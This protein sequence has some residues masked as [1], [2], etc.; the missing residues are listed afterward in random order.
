MSIR[1]NSIQNVRLS[2]IIS[3]W[4]LINIKEVICFSSLT[5]PSSYMLKQQQQQ[6]QKMDDIIINNKRNQIKHS[7]FESKNIL[8]MSKNYNDDSSSSP[9]NAAI[10]LVSKTL[11]TSLENLD[12]AFQKIRRRRG[13]TDGENEWKRLNLNDGDDDDE[14]DESINANSNNKEYVYLLSPP[15]T[16]KPS[17]VIIFL[18]G[19]V[20]GQFP[21][22]AYSELLQRLSLRMN[23]AILAIPYEVQLDHFSLAKQCATITQKALWKCDDEYNWGLEQ[24]QEEEEGEIITKG[25]IP[26]FA[27]SHSLGSKLMF[28]I[29]AANTKWIID[30]VQSI[31][32]MSF[33]NFSFVQSISML[34]SMVEQI[35]NDGSSSNTKDPNSNIMD[36]IFGFTEQITTG[37]SIEFYPNPESMEELISSKV[38]KDIINKSRFFCFDDDDLDCTQSI[39]PLCSSTTNNDDDLTISNLPG[40]HLTPVYWKLSL[41]DLPVDEVKDIA[42]QFTNGFR[43]ASFGDEES[44]NQLVDEVYNWMIGKGPSIKKQTAIPPRIASGSNNDN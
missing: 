19:A 10:E 43:S 40:N 5:R 28:I 9:S 35:R 25:N 15:Y 12:T 39:I 26:I 18:G 29:L 34:R 14:V 7:I 36:T 42:S 20:L 8:H 4:I 6:K 11:S 21:H 24:Q 44:L 17:C 41:D 3:C 2:F 13:S 31:G 22:I 37:L 30:D 23:A 16:E 32:F 1:N 27:L 33:N 38:N